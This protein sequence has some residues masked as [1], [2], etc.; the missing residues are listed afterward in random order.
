MTHTPVRHIPVAP[1]PVEVRRHRSGSASTGFSPR[2]IVPFRRYVS[3]LERADRQGLLR[4]R[5]R[6]S[7]VYRWSSAN[8]PKWP[9]TASCNK[10]GLPE[11]RTAAIG[12]TPPQVAFRLW[13]E[14][15]FV[16]Q[17]GR[18]ATVHRI[19]ALCFQWAPAERVCRLALSSAPTSET[20]SKV[21]KIRA[22]T[23]EQLARRPSRNGDTG[24]PKLDLAKKSAT[25][26]RRT[27][28]FPL[29]H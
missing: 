23:N 10:H 19:R 17:L 25:R 11:S 26:H 2:A 24:M 14:R 6:H 15:T 12:G 13:W 20:E 3:H 16:A 29:E 27:R 1:C 7:G 22:W 9:L 21:E 4:E 18:L 28:Y 8:I 5:R